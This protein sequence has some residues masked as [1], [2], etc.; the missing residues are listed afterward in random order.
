MRVLGTAYLAYTV[1]L[2]GLSG[3][4]NVAWGYGIGSPLRLL[5]AVPGLLWFAAL[6][7]TAGVVVTLPI[8][9]T[10]WLARR[11]L[12]SVA[13]GLIGACTLLAWGEW[14]TYRMEWFDV[15]RHGNPGLRYWMTTV[16]PTGVA[17]AAAGAVLGSAIGRRD[18]LG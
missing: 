10:L 15:W 8:W 7:F 17:W 13:A 2:F 14:S 16:V 3:A 5:R 11:R 4:L 1:V 12:D 9:A 18:R 6:L